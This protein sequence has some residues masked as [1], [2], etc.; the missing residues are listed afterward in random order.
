MP[1]LQSLGQVPHRCTTHWP[2][3]APW[4]TA[5]QA[6]PPHSAWVEHQHI[7]LAERRADAKSLSLS[8]CLSL[9]LPSLSNFF[10]HHLWSPTLWPLGIGKEALLFPHLSHIY[11][12]WKNS[13]QDPNLFTDLCIYINKFHTNFMFIDVRWMSQVY[14]NDGICSS[15]KRFRHRLRFLVGQFSATFLRI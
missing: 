9:S 11:K 12:N 2:A 4:S 15:V 10:S 3:I 1:W 6:L 14:H 5:Q 7:R 13:A 8:L